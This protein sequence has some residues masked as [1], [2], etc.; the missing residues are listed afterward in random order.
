MVFIDSFCSFVV[1]PLLFGDTIS[2]AVDLDGMPIAIEPSNEIKLFN[3]WSLNDVQV[4][5]ISLTVKLKFVVSFFC[6]IFDEFLF[7]DKFRFLK[8]YFLLRRIFESK[9]F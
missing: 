2:M 4:S 6:W 7:F 1:K 3:K 5:D 8:N 9:I